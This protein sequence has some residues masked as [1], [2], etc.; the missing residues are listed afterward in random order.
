M[1]ETLIEIEGLLGE[2]KPWNSREARIYSLAVA[3]I[4]LENEPEQWQ[5]ETCD[6]C[7]EHYASE[8]EY[9]ERRD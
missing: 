7:G 5:L 2:K 9:D 4:E 1:L 6:H 3:A 8:A